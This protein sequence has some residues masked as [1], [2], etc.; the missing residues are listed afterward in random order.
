[1]GRGSRGWGALQ[2]GAD[3]P[4]PLTLD[5]AAALRKVENRRN[6]MVENLRKRGKDDGEGRR[7]EVDDSDM[8]DCNELQVFGIWQTRNWERPGIDPKTGALP[9]NASGR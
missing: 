1:M 5:Q 6:R 8:R 9:R 4:V 3:G 7:N 2:V